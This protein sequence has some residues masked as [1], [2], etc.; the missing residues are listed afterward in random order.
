MLL[1]VFLV[2]VLSLSGFVQY[3]NVNVNQPIHIIQ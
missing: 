2:K 1:L 3:D